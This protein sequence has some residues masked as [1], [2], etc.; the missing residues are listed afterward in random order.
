MHVERFITVS[1]A[2]CAVQGATGTTTKRTSFRIIC[3]KDSCCTDLYWRFFGA[4][5]FS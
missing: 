3:C 1:Q 4:Q 2:H 5:K